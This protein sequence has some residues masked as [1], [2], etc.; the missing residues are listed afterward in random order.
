MDAPDI[1]NDSSV[2]FLNF[3]NRTEPIAFKTFVLKL[4]N[5]ISLF[6]NINQG[7]G[8]FNGSSEIRFNS[9]MQLQDASSTYVITHMNKNLKRVEILYPNSYPDANASNDTFQ[10]LEKLLDEMFTR[11]SDMSDNSINEVRYSYGENE[12]KLG[13]IHRDAMKFSSVSV[14]IN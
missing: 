6:K 2:E 14:I 8:E 11:D 5:A 3:Q 13:R 9:S 12:I 4:I 10:Q 1:Y 7:I